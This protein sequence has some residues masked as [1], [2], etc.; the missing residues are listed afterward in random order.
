MATEQSN[1]LSPIWKAIER[2]DRLSQL[3][4]TRLWAGLALGMA[5]SI[6]H[7]Q[8]GKKHGSGVEDCDLEI[9]QAI[10]ALASRTPQTQ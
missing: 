10:T 4:R 8:H 7:L 1:E 5:D 2:H 3:D 9:C 6:H